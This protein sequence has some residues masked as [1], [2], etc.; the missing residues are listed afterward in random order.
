M[1]KIKKIELPDFLKPYYINDLIRTQPIQ[2]M[3]VSKFSLFL[4]TKVNIV[5]AGEVNDQQGLM[6]P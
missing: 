5:L 2:Q 4:F 1:S 6:P 3:K